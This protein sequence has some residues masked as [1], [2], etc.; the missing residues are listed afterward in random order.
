MGLSAEEKERLACEVAATFSP[1]VPIDERTLFAGRRPQIR[2][3]ISAITQRGQH[4]IIF[5]ERGVGKTSLAKVLAGFLPAAGAVKYLTRSGGPFFRP[6][7]APHITCDGT[8][9]YSTLWRKIFSA[10]ERTSKGTLPAEGVPEKLAP[11]HVMERLSRLAAQGLLLCVIVDEFDRLRNSESR[12]LFADTIKILSDHAVPATLVLVGVADTVEE[13]IED[14]QSIERALVQVRLPRM[15]REEVREVLK[16]G[17]SKVGMEMDETALGRIALLSRGFPYYAHL[18]GLNAAHEAIASDEKRV[19]GAHVDAAIKR[20]VGE[21][22]QT[23]RSAYKKA[24]LGLRKEGLHPP[25]LLACALAETDELGYFSAADVRDS[26]SLVL[27]KNL[28]ILSFARHLCDFCEAKRGPVLQRVRAEGRVL[29]RFHNPLMQA[30][31][32][33][34]AH[35]EGRV[36][37]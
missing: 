30:F 17:M 7:A 31:V 3:L 22:P 32:A 19:G 9:D 33:M 29:F 12:R 18:L 36:G 37:P 5:G 21:A 34:H 27:G 6:I 28:E 11:D 8:D 35:A 16:M 25:V 15:A 26:L 13:L 20:V 4:A 23:L 14:H 24:A 1:A 10:A 2:Q